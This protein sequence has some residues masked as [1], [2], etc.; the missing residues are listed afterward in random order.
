MSGLS[1]RQ[2]GQLAG[3]AT[4]TGGLSA[5]LAQQ[6]TDQRRGEPFQALFAPHPD[7]LPT[8]PKTYLDQLQFAYDL[9]FRA[10]EDNQLA[11]QSP[12]IQQQVGQFAREKGLTLGVMVISGGAGMAFCQPTAAGRA[13]LEKDMHRGVEVAK[14]TGQTWMTMLPGIRVEGL[15]LQ[16][17]IAGAVEL[18]TVCCDMVEEH[19]IIM[20]L[21]PLS[22][23]IQG[24]PPLLRSFEDGFQLCQ[25]VNRKSCK[26]LADFFH[27]GQIGNDLIPSAEQAW[28][29]VAYIQYG[30]V[31]GRNEPGTGKLDYQA[32]TRWLREQDYQGVIGMEHGASQ[33]GPAGLDALLRAYRA[34]DA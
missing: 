27:E 6:Q 31:P 16:E 21:E 22:H 20:V 30:D 12:Q 26:L 23:G 7:L 28:P 19:G 15:P 11:R 18:M 33:Q 2:F 3:A 32:V 29:E 24:G 14:R 10:W 13:Q 34:I 4:L 8:G 17:Q 9:G 25:Q 1:R 5:A